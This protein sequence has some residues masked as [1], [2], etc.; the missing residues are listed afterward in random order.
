MK[1]SLCS[2]IESKGEISVSRT[3]EDN[4]EPIKVMEFKEFLESLSSILLR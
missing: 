4:D 1:Y 3:T 2:E